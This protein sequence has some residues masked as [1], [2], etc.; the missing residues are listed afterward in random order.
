MRVIADED[1][2]PLGGYAVLAVLTS[3]YARRVYPLRLDGPRLLLVF[4]ATGGLLLGSTTLTEPVHG[5]MAGAG[6]HLGLA[7]VAALGGLALATGPWQEL[8]SALA[9]PGSRYHEGPKEN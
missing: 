1:D 6:I 3:W 5:T 8:R 4:A 7:A 9:R 2:W